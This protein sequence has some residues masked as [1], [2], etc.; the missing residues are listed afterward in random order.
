MM[1]WAVHK[2]LSIPRYDGFL[3]L[4]CECNFGEVSI[5][6][7]QLQIRANLPIPQDGTAFAVRIY[8]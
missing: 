4:H 7:Y 5:S 3:K 8:P 6:H 1:L 2:S